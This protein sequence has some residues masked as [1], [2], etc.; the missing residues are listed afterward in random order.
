MH[1]FILPLRWGHGEGSFAGAQQK[2]RPLRL[3]GGCPSAG[4][5]LT[6]VFPPSTGAGAP[7]HA[8]RPANAG[9]AEAP[10]ALPLIS[11]YSIPPDKLDAAPT[12]TRHAAK[13]RPGLCA[14][15]GGGR[16]SSRCRPRRHTPRR[17]GSR[18]VPSRPVPSRRVP[19]GPVPSLRAARDR[20]RARG[21]SSGAP[22]SAAAPAARPL[23]NPQLP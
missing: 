10:L 15:R 1:P 21:P 13:P 17:V 19:L 6:P 11:A 20:R 7:C 4:A 2:L 22:R 18:P 23:E 5:G 16:S 9:I 3:C 8:T 14:E 12:R